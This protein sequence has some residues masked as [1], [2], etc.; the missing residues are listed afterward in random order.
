MK[1]ERKVYF[2][3]EK[4]EIEI[5]KI[6]EKTPT[7]YSVIPRN[8]DYIRIN[9]SEFKR[10]I[11]KVELFMEER[12][13]ATIKDNTLYLESNNE[14]KKLQGIEEIR[15]DKKEGKDITFGFINTYMSK[16]RKSTRLN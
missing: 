1:D 6:E 10:A 2:K 9:K 12:I 5:I 4:T 3:S 14:D 15:I 16:D 11:N 7:Y 8:E 13:K